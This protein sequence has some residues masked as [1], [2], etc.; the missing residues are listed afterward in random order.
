MGLRVYKL[1]TGYRGAPHGDVDAAV[2]AISAVARYIAANAERLEEL[3]IN[4]V[5]VLPEGE[6]VLAVDALI[7]IREET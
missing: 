5:L 7:R 6:G 4:P 1:M 2:A 3:D